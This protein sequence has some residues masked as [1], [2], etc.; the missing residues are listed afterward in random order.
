MFF[1]NL[2]QRRLMSD[3][4]LEAETVVRVVEAATIS[5]DASL[6]VKAESEI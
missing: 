2:E 3:K 4:L 5:A 6:I 1:S